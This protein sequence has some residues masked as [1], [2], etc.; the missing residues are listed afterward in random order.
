MGED[1]TFATNPATSWAGCGV[2][3]DRQPDPSP[4]GSD[5]QP[6][7]PPPLLLDTRHALVG[8]CAASKRVDVL[9]AGSS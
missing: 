9:I 3:D 4:E 1:Q 6:N 7:M 5:P 8:R 2:R